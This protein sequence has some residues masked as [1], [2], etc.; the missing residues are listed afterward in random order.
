MSEREDELVRHLRVVELS[1]PGIS[2]E[3]ALGRHAAR[4]RA[5]A[6]PLRWMVAAAIAAWLLV[7][8]GGNLGNR[9]LRQLGASDA[10]ICRNASD[11]DYLRGM[12]ARRLEALA[13]AANGHDI[14]PTPQPQTTAPR[15][16]RKRGE[17]APMPVC[18]GDGRYV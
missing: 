13:D 9:D 7:F 15:D 18:E 5:Q 6:R 4:R 3:D 11:P 8:V 1:R 14:Q 2:L 16:P 12:F 17:E 10:S